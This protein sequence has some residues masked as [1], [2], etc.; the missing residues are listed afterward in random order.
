MRPY[1]NPE[2]LAVFGANNSVLIKTSTEATIDKYLDRKDTVYRDMRMLKDPG[3]YEAIGG[4]SYLS[5]F[6][7]GL[8]L[9]HSP[10]RQRQR[11]A[12]RWGTLHWRHSVHLSADGTYTANYKNL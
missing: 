12:K 3:N 4:D 11:P 2:L 8:K 1:L 7:K 5:G 6:V 10:H 9:R